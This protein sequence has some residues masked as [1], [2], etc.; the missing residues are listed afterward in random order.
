MLDSLANHEMCNS[1]MQ[2]YA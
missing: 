2:R 1:L